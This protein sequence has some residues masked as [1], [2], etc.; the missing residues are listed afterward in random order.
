M[1]DGWIKVELNVSDRLLGCDICFHDETPNMR[2][3]ESRAS[4]PLFWEDR[5]HAIFTAHQMISLLF[6]D[7][8]TQ[9]LVPEA[10]KAEA[11]EK[12]RAQAGAGGSQQFHFDVNDLGSLFR[13]GRGGGGGGFED[14]LGNLFGGGGTRRGPMRGQ[15]SEYTTEVTLE[16]AYAGTKRTL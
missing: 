4:E 8:P 11:F 1:S 2:L 5:T 3:D 7:T 13:Q 15:N 9:S 14:V 12:A 6:R 16:E 10:A